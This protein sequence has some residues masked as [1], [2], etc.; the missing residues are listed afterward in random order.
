M[1]RNKYILR[2]SVESPNAVRGGHMTWTLLYALDATAVRFFFQ[3]IRANPFVPR[4][5]SLTAGNNKPT[6]LTN[7]IMDIGSR[8]HFPAIRNSFI[9][10]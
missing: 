2:K 7:Q 1:K 3:H 8:L 9:H 6:L 5:N 4:R 10:K